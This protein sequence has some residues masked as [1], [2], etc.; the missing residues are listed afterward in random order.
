MASSTNDN[1]PMVDKFNGDKFGLWKFKME[2]VL[3]AKDLWDIVDKSESP[4]PNDAEKS[5]KKEKTVGY[6][7]AL[8]IIAMN[9]VDREVLHIKT[10]TILEMREGDTH[11]QAQGQEMKRENS[12][13][14]LPYILLS[15]H[16]PTKSCFDFSNPTCLMEVS[17]LTSYLLSHSR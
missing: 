13:L 11:I 3:A 9:L 6:K 5:T 12:S 2:M 8:A 16:Q 17:L 14:C 10:C 4:P 15:Q 1:V 7:K